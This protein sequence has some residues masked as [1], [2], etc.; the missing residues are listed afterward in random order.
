MLSLLGQNEEMH[1]GRNGCD[2]L[3]SG[4]NENNNQ[5]STTTTAIREQ[6]TVTYEERKR[7]DKGIDIFSFSWVYALE[8]KPPWEFS[9]AG[10]TRA[11]IQKAPTAFK[12]T[13][14]TVLRRL[15]AKSRKFFVKQC[16]WV[17][18]I[19]YRARSWRPE[20]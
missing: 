19:K 9:R 5:P 20:R 13:D 17:M 7:T 8:L 6:I 15:R 3:S 1:S 16:R 14:W 2:T 12:Q 11:L 4:R 10:Y 18:W